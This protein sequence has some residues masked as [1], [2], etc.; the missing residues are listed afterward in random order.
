[1]LGLFISYLEDRFHIRP[2]LGRRKAR[3]QSSL[4]LYSQYDGERPSCSA[5]KTWE[6]E[7]FLCWKRRWAYTEE[8]ICNIFWSAKVGEANNSRPKQWALS[9]CADLPAL[10]L[11]FLIS[12]IVPIPSSST[13]QSLPSICEASFIKGIKS[14]NNAVA[15]SAWSRSSRAFQIGPRKKIKFI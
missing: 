12:R 3:E 10:I 15:N 5:L 4:R 11:G 6:P 14:L 1:M 2:Y 7:N 13:T 9:S 8:S